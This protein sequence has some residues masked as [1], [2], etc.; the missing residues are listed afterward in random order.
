MSARYKAEKRLARSGMGEV[1]LARDL[2]AGGTRVVVK[3][4]LPSLAVDSEIVALFDRE[5]AISR[6]IDHPN[7][8]RILDSG[9][10]KGVPFIVMEWLDGIDVRGVQL[11]LRKRGGD[12]RMPIETACAVAAAVARGLVHAHDL[13]V[14]HRDV[15][16]DNVFLTKTGEVKLLDFGIARASELLTL[17]RT[18]F[19]RGKRGYMSPEQVAGLAIDPRSDVFSL[20]VVLWEMLTSRRLWKRDTFEETAFAIRQ[21]PA[22]PPSTIASGIPRR[23]DALTLAMLAKLA[24][25]RPAP[26]TVVTELARPDERDLVVALVKAHVTC[27]PA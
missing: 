8:V 11:A 27:T 14:I 6:K 19:T 3:R 26:S 20:G 10:S 5:I 24:G 25:S 15:S 13:G 18:G 21:E 23:L 7:V 22:A 16:P 9:R 17:T 1:L 4:L 2:E 12:A